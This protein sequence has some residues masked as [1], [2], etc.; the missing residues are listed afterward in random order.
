MRRFTDRFGVEILDG[1]GSTEALHIFL[2]NR[3]GAVRPGTTGQVV[4]GYELR[5]EDDDGNPVPVGTPGNLYVRGDSI[6]TGYWC[7][8]ETTRRVFR[9][10]WLRTGDT[11]VCD[12]EGFYSC[13]GRTDD[14][15]KAGGI[16]VSPA[17]VETRLR[18]HPDVASVA[19]VSVPDADGLDKPVAVVVPIPGRSPSPEELIA[20]C[21]GGLAAFKRPRSVLVVDELPQT[22]TGK[23]QRFRVREMAAALLTGERTA[24]AAP[25]TQGVPAQSVTPDAGPA[26]TP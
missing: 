18:E 25:A 16:W 5:L 12:A 10:P 2:S 22:A 17:E 1:I 9:G 4:S 21:R 3:A 19:V 13:L 15:L 7:R 23:L 8:T 6:A 14:V 24:P 20:F 11:Y 26:G